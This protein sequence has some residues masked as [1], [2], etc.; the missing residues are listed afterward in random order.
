MHS[1]SHI[2]KRPGSSRGAIYKGWKIVI[3]NGMTSENAKGIPKYAMTKKNS[4]R[5]EKTNYISSLINSE[6]FQW[7]TENKR[8]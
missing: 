4:G 3:G 2:H 1:L 6:T 5:R 8:K 7:Y